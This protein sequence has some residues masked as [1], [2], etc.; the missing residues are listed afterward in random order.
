MKL[1]F[2]LYASSQFSYLPLLE[3][4]DGR[5]LKN[6]RGGKLTLNGLSKMLQNP[7]YVGLIRIKTTGA[8]YQGIH[9][10]LI[11]MATWKQVQDV[12]TGRSGPKVT[13]HNHLFQGLF[14]CAHCG[15]PMVPEL[16][17]Q[18]VYYRCKRK[19][20]PTK[21]IRE[22]VLEAAISR[23]L[24]QL[25]LS[26]AAKAKSEATSPDF[27]SS[28]EEQRTAL[29]L[30]LA[31]EERRLERLQDLLLDEK[32]EIGMFDS[33]KEEL[34]LRIVALKEDL[35]K[36][37]NPDELRER[38][39]QLA[40]LQKNLVLLY[41]MANR[42]EKRLIV[43]NVWPNRTVSGKKPLFEPDTWLLKANCGQA[44]TYGAPERD[45]RRILIDLIDK[46][47]SRPS[48]AADA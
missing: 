18:R 21:T 28:L 23:E 32:I 48:D 13:R 17:K 45:R 24:Q 22:D 2:E 16:Q 19:K 40:E 43:E 42:T 14:T 27:Y 11:D 31:D 20:C 3:E 12:R 15:D 41:E 8:T 46:L 6:F 35:E 36:L 1:A 39:K 47:R 29:T 34:Q 5:G 9:E 25:Q 4:L 38:K 33:K 10:P 30:Q 7:F 44:F 37:P 26:P